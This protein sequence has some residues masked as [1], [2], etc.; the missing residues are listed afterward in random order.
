MTGSIRHSWI[1]LLGNIKE[2]LLVEQVKTVKVILSVIGAKIAHFA[3]NHYTRTSDN[4]V[5][6]W[7]TIVQD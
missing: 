1:F 2:A 5:L 3:Q 6:R 7:D 4:A